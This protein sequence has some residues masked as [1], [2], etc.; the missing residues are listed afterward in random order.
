MK[1]FK[2]E[3]WVMWRNEHGITRRRLLNISDWIAVVGLIPLIVTAIYNEGY[4]GAILSLLAGGC[5]IVL[6]VSFFRATSLVW[7]RDTTKL[8]L[9]DYQSYNPSE[10]VK[11]E[12]VEL[13]IH[14]NNEIRMDIKWFNGTVFTLHIT[15]VEGHAKIE[16]IELNH[17]SKLVEQDCYAGKTETT[18]I[19]FSGKEQLLS[20]LN[21]RIGDGKPIEVMPILNWSLSLVNGETVPFQAQLPQG[22]KLIMPKHN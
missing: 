12:L 19:W 4:I 3:V 2:H 21:S 10:F 18:Q 17:I 20:R 6:L 16:E 11:A 15:S 14:N 5:A 1:K 7:Q 8:Q 9:I 22:A 13:S